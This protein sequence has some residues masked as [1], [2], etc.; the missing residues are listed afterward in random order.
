MMTVR[1]RKESMQNVHEANQ[2]VEHQM[3][4][5]TPRGM[6]IGKPKTKV[7]ENLDNPT[8]TGSELDYRRSN[9]RNLKQIRKKNRA[10]NRPRMSRPR[11]VVI[12][13]ETEEE[14][15]VQEY[16]EP[17]EAVEEV[18]EPTVVVEDTVEPVAVVEEAADHGSL[19]SRRW[20]C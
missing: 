14:E 12:Q 15:V 3:A 20:W 19:R 2:A 11:P 1:Q 6:G 18:N 7:I 5:I 16:D 4:S 17:I 9:R 8:D 10:R 13:R